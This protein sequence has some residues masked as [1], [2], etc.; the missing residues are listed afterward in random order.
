MIIPVQQVLLATHV[1]EDGQ[2]FW[3]A[4]HVKLALKAATHGAVARMVAALSALL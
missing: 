2:R 3:P 4:G 1:D